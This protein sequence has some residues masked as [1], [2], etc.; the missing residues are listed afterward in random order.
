MNSAGQ[1]LE[2]PP[3]KNL[4]VAIH[5]NTDSIFSLP[6]NQLRKRDMQRF[7]KY[8]A[9]RILTIVEPIGDRLFSSS[10]DPPSMPKIGQIGLVVRRRSRDRY[11]VERLD[12]HGRT[13]WLCEFH[14]NEI[15]KVS[16]AR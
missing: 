15:E 13:E 14:E 8:T 4:N 1:L 16:P 10:Y 5:T 3:G 11:L 6:E 2:R 9:V 7:N 12:G